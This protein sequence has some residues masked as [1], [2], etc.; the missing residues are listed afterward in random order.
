MYKYEDPLGRLR[1]R[2][3]EGDDFPL[4]A[5]GG[6]DPLDVQDSEYLFS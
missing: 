4:P 3:Y 5:Y 2:N 6:L 1:A